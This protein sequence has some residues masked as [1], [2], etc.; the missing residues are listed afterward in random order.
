MFRTPDIEEKLQPWQ[1]CLRGSESAVWPILN[2]MGRTQWTSPKSFNI[3]NG[4]L[5]FYLSSK[6]LG[7]VAHRL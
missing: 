4:F 5:R 3:A 7:E 1:P 6:G 2:A